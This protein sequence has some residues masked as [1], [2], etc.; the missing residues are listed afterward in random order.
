MH[1][2]KALGLVFE[3]YITICSIETFQEGP[4]MKY[5]NPCLSLLIVLGVSGSTT[6]TSL[7]FQRIPQSSVSSTRGSLL[8]YISS[9]IHPLGTSGDGSGNNSITNHLDLRVRIE[10]LS[11]GS[12]RLLNGMETVFDQY[13]FGR[14]RCCIRSSRELSLSTDRLPKSSSLHWILGAPISGEC[15]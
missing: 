13:F 6:A 10:C 15:V 11:G 5:R 1:S 12:T 2:I 3:R 4:I 7:E 14:Q 8:P 9:D